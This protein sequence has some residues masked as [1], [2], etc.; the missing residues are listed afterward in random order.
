MAR[1]F[2]ARTYV[3]NFEKVNLAVKHCPQREETKRKEEKEAAP[4]RVLSPVP[5]RLPNKR[6]TRI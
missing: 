5:I 6:L 1:L 2:S 3:V 4:I